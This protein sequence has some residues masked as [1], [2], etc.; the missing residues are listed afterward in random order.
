MLTGK[1]IVKGETRSTVTY[2]KN[3]MRQNTVKVAKVKVEA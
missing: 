3:V 1:M 2:V